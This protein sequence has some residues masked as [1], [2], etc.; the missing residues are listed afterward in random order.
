MVEK[1]KAL[2]EAYPT[3]HDIFQNAILITLI[4]NVKYT[5]H[6]VSGSND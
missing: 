1:K 2:W 6:R 5:F 4:K 3:F